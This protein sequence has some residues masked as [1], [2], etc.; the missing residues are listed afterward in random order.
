MK[1]VTMCGS[2]RFN[3]EM[4]VIA[5]NLETKKGWAVIQCIYSQKR[6]KMDNIEE[7]HNIEN[8]HFKKI[9][10]CDCIYVVNKGGYIGEA[11]K[12]AIA[13]AKKKGKEIIYHEPVLE[14]N[15]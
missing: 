15:K 14:G 1:V 9:E 2:M 11:T 7:M 10:L 4:R 6:D 5:R 8:A 12:R 3:K 13:Y